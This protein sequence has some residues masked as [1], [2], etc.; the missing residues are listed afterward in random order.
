M[1][2]AA[3]DPLAG[4]IAHFTAVSCGFDAL[5]SRIALF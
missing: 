1:A 4:I 2:L 5:A 3:L